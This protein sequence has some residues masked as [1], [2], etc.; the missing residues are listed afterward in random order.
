MKILAFGASNSSASINKQFASYAA[1][2][3]KGADVHIIDLNDF[4]MPIYGIDKEKANGIPEQVHQFKAVIDEVDAIIIS[5]AEHNGAYTAAYKNIYDW[6][7][8]AYKNV[9]ENKPMLL[10]STSPGGRGG[11]GV[12]EIAQKAYSYSNPNVIG[13]FAL[14]SFNQNFSMENGINDVEL[15]NAFGNLIQKLVAH[16]ANAPQ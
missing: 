6:V 11:I 9:W 15:K 14:P 12:L 4:E 10:L 16:L 5:F 1:H 3:I 8:R 7:S 2:Q 13:S